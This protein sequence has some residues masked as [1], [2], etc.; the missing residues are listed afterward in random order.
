MAVGY[1][2]GGR[3]YVDGVARATIQ[4]NW[5]VSA[6]VAYPVTP[7]QGFSLAIATGGNRGAGT[8]ADAVSVAYQVAWGKH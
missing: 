1:G 2:Y 8:D 3:T 4:R 6:M 5:R 7:S